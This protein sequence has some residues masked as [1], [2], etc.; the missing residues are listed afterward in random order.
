MARNLED[1]K[2]RLK[3][4]HRA[5]RALE[6]SD[7]SS[8]IRD[9]R[10]GA[11]VKR[12]SRRRN[13]WP[14]V[15]ARFG[16][17]VVTGYVLGPKR[18]VR[19]LILNCD[20]G[21]PEYMLAANCVTDFHM[22][23]CDACAYKYRGRKAWWN[24]AG[25]V[26]EPEHRIRLMCR[27]RA[28]IRRCHSPNDPS[29]RNYG[30]RGIAVYEPWR[31]DLGLVLAYLK[32]LPGWDNPAVELDRIDN[33]GGYAPGN[34]RFGSKRRNIRN[35]RSVV[36]LRKKILRLRRRIERARARMEGL[37]DDRGLATRGERESA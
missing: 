29:Y 27:I 31:R 15:G 16:S 4:N 2:A 22:T 20:C 11:A 10:S 35:R 5:L 34:L 3:A 26:R 36:E 33:D 21:Q 14:D 7:P 24:Y 17:I 37:R 1:A 25:I 13:P 9:R 8:V 18:G 32:D 6:K 23:Y 12:T 19:A 28:A 30:G